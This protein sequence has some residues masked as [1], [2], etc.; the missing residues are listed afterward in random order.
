MVPVLRIIQ[1]NTSEMLLNWLGDT[2]SKS[3]IHDFTEVISEKNE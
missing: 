3:M 1:T 2:I